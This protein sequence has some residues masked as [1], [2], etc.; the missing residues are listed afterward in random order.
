M[1]IKLVK[2]EMAS[3]EVDHASGARSDGSNSFCA[4]S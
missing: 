2:F 3:D 4:G 1:L